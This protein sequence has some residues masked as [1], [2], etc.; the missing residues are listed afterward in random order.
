MQ[1]VDENVS[2]CVFPMSAWVFYIL[3]EVF[4]KK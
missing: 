2:S 1:R 3:F 4:F